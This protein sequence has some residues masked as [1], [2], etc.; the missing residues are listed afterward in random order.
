MRIDMIDDARGSDQIVTLAFHAQ[1]MLVQEGGA[2]GAP[3]FRAIERTGF[4]ITSPRI[5]LVA[6]TLLAPSNGTV[7]RWTNGHDADLVGWK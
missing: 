5:I 1:W 2:F 4:W 7:D 6:L 3:A